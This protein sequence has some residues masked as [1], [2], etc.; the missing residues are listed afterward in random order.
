MPVAYRS[1]DGGQTGPV[2]FDLYCRGDV[3]LFC[4]KEDCTPKSRK[5][6]ALLAILAAEQ[7]PLTRVRIVDL[8]WSDRQEE[9]AR[10]SLRTLLADMRQQFNSGFDDLLVVERERIALGPAVR[11]DLTDPALARPAGELFEGLDH[12]DPE[13]DE[14]L[15]IERERWANRHQSTSRP[16]LPGTGRRRNALGIL[17]AVLLIALLLAGL[18]YFPSGGSPADAR[19]AVLPFED[20]SGSNETLARGLAEQLRLE[21]SLQRNLGVISSRSSQSEVIAGKDLREAARLLGASHVLEGAVMP[22]EGSLQM[23]LRLIDGRSGEILWSHQGPASPT[24]I[25]GGDD[26]IAPKIAGVVGAIATASAP[27]EVMTADSRAYQSVFEARSLMRTYDPDEAVKAR[28][29]MTEVVKRNP[30]FVPALITFAESNIATSDAPGMN[31]SIPIEQARKV[32]L[33][34]AKRAIRLAPDYGP[35][36]SAMGAAYFNMKEGEA[37][38]QIAAK[39]TPGSGSAHL[40]WG[41]IL[42]QN[43]RWIEAARE[44]KLA[45]ELDPLGETAQWYYALSLVET[46]RRD[47]AQAVIRNY[48]ALPISAQHRL[49]VAPSIASYLFTDLASGYVASRRGVAA[50]PDDAD[51]IASALTEYRRLYGRKAALP[52]ARRHASLTA[53]AVIDDPQAVRRRVAELGRDFWASSYDID[54][55]GQYLVRKGYHADLVRA[56]DRALAAGMPRNDKAFASEPLAVALRWA[57]RRDEA[58]AVVAHLRTVLTG[59][60]GRDYRRTAYRW[61]LLHALEGKRDKAL[62]A[63]ADAIRHRSWIVNDVIDAPH[64]HVALAGLRADPRFGEL[65]RRFDEDIARERARARRMERSAGPGE[66]PAA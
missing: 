34:Y 64:D 21:L 50:L 5:G 35:A 41:I 1:V 19:I 13:L 57:G 11:T 30:N 33:H 4:G 58:A 18:R 27:A 61:A 48:L 56:Y 12:I 14:W 7:R 51:V 22:F 6:R 65:K 63:L 62:A 31:G 38:D 53:L 36:Y 66:L 25:V 24:E 60:Q 59:E 32:A 16:A 37:Y 2:A 3:R 43:G 28:L 26:P 49:T 42:F 55:A 8:L 10:A 15:R 40:N 20:V 47:A 54:V 39:L 17:A 46:G 52:F 29:L 44:L 9:Q 23:S 45:A